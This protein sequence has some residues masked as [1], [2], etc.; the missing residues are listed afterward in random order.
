MML[1]SIIEPVTRSWSYASMISGMHA[2]S[3]NSRRA[4]AYCAKIAMAYV[5]VGVMVGMETA[6]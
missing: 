6:M 5:C 4:A 3:S 1:S 2:P